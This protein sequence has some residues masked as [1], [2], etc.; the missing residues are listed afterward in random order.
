MGW[1]ETIT[2]NT[3]SLKLRP[4]NYV[5]T[6]QTKADLNWHLLSHVEYTFIPK[7]IRKVS[8]KKRSGSQGQS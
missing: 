4:S 5:I 6:S 1:W 8:W 3:F 2:Q 7:V